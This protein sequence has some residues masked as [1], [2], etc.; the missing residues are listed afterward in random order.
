MT[1]LN[2]KAPNYFGKKLHL[3][4]LTGFCMRLW[5]GCYFMKHSKC[6]P[7][8]LPRQNFT[9]KTRISIPYPEVLSSKPLGGPKVNSD[10]HPSEVD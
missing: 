9:K 8:S 6:L 10:F 4:F 3:S 7:G 1:I 2:G 5:K